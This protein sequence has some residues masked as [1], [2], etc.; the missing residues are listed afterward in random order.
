MRVELRS[1][2]PACNPYLAFAAMLAAGLA[3]I[4]GNYELPPPME[5]NPFTMSESE[6]RS[7]NIMQLP[8]DLN[9]AIRYAENSQLLRDCLGDHL[10]E[11]FIENKKIEWETYRR[12][13]TEFELRRY[14]PIL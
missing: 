9:A 10:L 13:V 7:R 3:G 1:P 5:D 12:Q 4:E 8:E 11:K 14:L 6:R 2:D